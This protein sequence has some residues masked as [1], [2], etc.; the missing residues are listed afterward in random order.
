MLRRQRRRWKGEVGGCL[1][2]SRLFSATTA[3]LLTW[4]KHRHAHPAAASPPRRPPTAPPNHPRTNSVTAV[5]K[6]QSAAPCSATGFVAAPRRSVQHARV[7]MLALWSRPSAAPGACRCLSCVSRESQLVAVR[8]RPPARVCAP[9][10]AA[11]LAVDAKP[12]RKK[13]KQ[14]EDAF[15]LLQR[16]L[17]DKAL[18]QKTCDRSDAARGGTD[19]PRAHR[20]GTGDEASEDVQWDAAHHA[21][22]MDT[23][24]PIVSQEQIQ[25]RAEAAWDDL[26]YDSRLPG[27]ESPEWPA[28]TGRPVTRHH[29]PPQSLWAHDAVRLTAMRRRHTWKKL[30]MQ[31]LST[32]LLCHTLMTRVGFGRWSKFSELPPNL[33]AVSPQIQEMASFSSHRAER[34]RAEILAMIDR[35]H[36]THVGSTPEQIAKANI[37]VDQPGIPRYLQ[38]ADGDFYAICQ[39]MNA[40]I[41]RLLSVKPTNDA[42]EEASTIAKICHNLLVSTAAPD[43]QTFNLLVAGFK[44]WRRPRLVDDVIAAL[45]G[46]Q[47]RPNEIACREILGHY[48]NESRPDDFSRFVAKMRG[49]GDALMLASPDIN[50]NQ[51]GQDRLIRIDENKVYQKVH[52]TPMVFGALITGVMRFA[53]F[54]RA[55]DIYYE[56][57]AD[58]WGLDMDS[59]IALLRDCIHRADWEG[60]MYVW[61]EISSILANAKTSA[62]AKAYFH[63]LSLCSVT[64]NTVTFN[65]VLSEV[66]KRGLNRKSIIDA[67]E[68][69]S[70]AARLRHGR[71]AP[72]WAADN[73]MIAVSAY[74]DDAKSSAPNS[75]SKPEH[76]S[77]SSGHVAGDDETP[78]DPKEAWASWVE[79]EFGE[80][81]KDPEL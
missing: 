57:K 74:V 44:R 58:G 2:T 42:R 28:N 30:A 18:L 15:V 61:D 4:R 36:V 64:G 76:E 70:Q 8:P 63:M 67:A 78:L 49:V 16:E 48:M 33:D 5:L 79:A 56:M 41:M 81:P 3:N 75:K 21:A 54:D 60:G 12:R 45:Y 55:L 47:I 9:V 17:L 11:G 19:E 53:G 73:V 40:G 14:W 46:S 1:L 25:A 37:H 34:A 26:R 23:A 29:L 52:P 62:V 43:L 59:L 77:K 32:G 35:L 27:A 6:V 10:F 72:A 31:E 13:N 51:A 22:G 68:R 71:L 24:D 50:I 7:A 38:D 66:V 20:D 39:Q 69:T 65:Q 80:R